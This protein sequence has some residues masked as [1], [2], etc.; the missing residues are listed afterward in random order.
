M[1]ANDVDIERGMREMDLL[2]DYLNQ[3]IINTGRPIERD[4]HGLWKKFSITIATL[5]G[6]TY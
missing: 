3:V 2:T 4:N 1:N 6:L 5:I